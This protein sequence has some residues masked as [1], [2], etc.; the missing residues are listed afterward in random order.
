M[1]DLRDAVDR[2][3]NVSHRD[4]AIRSL[5]AAGA[6]AIPFL[7]QGMTH[8]YWRVRHM[9]CRLLD[10]LPLSAE[11]LR[12]LR[13]LAR[14][15]PNKRVRHQAWHAATCEACKPDGLEASCGVDPV[16]D[17]ADQ[18]EDCSLRVRRAAATGLIFAT[19]NPGVDASRLDTLI[20]RVLVTETDT[21]ITG[22][23]AR[24]RLLLASHTS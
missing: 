2:L 9:C 22:R 7:R 24:A 21:T 5:V 10:D 4:D 13:E 19:Q 3:G 8:P 1:S 23:A 20:G 18:F 12:E 6:V 16:A 17:L 15:D 11:V 14:S